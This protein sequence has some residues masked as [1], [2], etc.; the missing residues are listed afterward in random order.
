MAPRGAQ[1]CAQPWCG[2]LPH[3][4]R[5]RRS[6]S[7]RGEHSSSRRSAG[8]APRS[9]TVC[10]SQPSSSC[11]AVKPAWLLPVWAAF[12]RATCRPCGRFPA[13][14]SFHRWRRLSPTLGAGL[15]RRRKPRA[16]SIGYVASMRLV[17]H[18]RGGPGG[19]TTALSR[20]GT[21]RQR[22]SRCVRSG[23]RRSPVVVPTRSQRAVALQVIGMTWMSAVAKDPHPPTFHRATWRTP[24][25]R[26]REGADSAFIACS[27]PA[28]ARGGAG[29]FTQDRDPCEAS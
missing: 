13:G 10:R 20:R 25:T 1:R 17:E 27:S 3:R 15:L 19:G 12:P 28:M 18:V 2:P 9:T 7:A 29:A 21:L 5:H 23:A 14:R 16:V 6:A 8:R 22:K 4:V 11:S 26:H 24:G